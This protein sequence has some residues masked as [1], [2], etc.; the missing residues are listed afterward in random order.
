VPAV[1]AEHLLVTLKN[2]AATLRDADVP[3]ALCGGLAAWARGG[4]P[5]EKD[6]DLLIREDD[7]ERAHAALAAAGFRT[8]T[9]PEGWLVKAFDGDILIDLIY[10]PSGLVVDDELLAR[11]DEMSVHALTMKVMPIDDLMS[12]KLLA[13][14]EHH[15]DFGPPLEIARALREQIDWARLWERTEGSPFARTFF[16]LLREL[17]ILTDVPERS[18]A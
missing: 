13:L 5:T 2:V 17:G 4:P 15:L 7:R 14:A 18:P 3:F 12:S 9:P 11:C 6:I 1:Q 8:E 16:T 10:R